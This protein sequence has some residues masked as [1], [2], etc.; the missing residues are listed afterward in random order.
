MVI[1]MIKRSPSI[2]M[3][4]K[5]LHLKKVDATVLKK[6]I[7]NARSGRDVDQVMELANKMLGG[8]GVE[9]I[10]HEAMWIDHYYQN[11]GLLYVNKGDTYNV[12]ICYDTDKGAMFV[13]SW[14]DWVESNKEIQKFERQHN[15]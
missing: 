3:M 2:D 14:G 4:V 10:S 9:S 11:H 13:G 1:E 7:K 12:T 15:W 8:Y 5:R 6:A